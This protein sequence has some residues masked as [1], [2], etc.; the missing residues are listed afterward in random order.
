MI[1]RRWRDHHGSAISVRPSVVSSSPRPPRFASDTSDSEWIASDSPDPKVKEIYG[2]PCSAPC[3]LV[4]CYDMMETTTRIHLL[5]SVD[6]G[7]PT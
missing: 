7:S 3:V 2:R 6:L 4:N 5:Q 1:R